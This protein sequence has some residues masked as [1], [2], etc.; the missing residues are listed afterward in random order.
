MS[1]PS[2]SGS[3][4]STASRS[5]S[6]ERAGAASPG[7]WSAE[8]RSTRSPR[9]APA[10][11]C[12][13]WRRP[14]T[15]PRPSVQAPQDHVAGIAEARPVAGRP[16]QLLVLE[17][18]KKRVPAVAAPLRLRPDAREGLRSQRV[19]ARDRDSRVVVE[20]AAHLHG[21]DDSPRPDLRCRPDARV[22]IDRLALPHPEQVEADDVANVHRDRGREGYGARDRRRLPSETVRQLRPDVARREKARQDD[23]WKGGQQEPD[24]P[25]VVE[26]LVE[27][28][29]AEKPREPREE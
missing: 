9:R 24:R 17:V 10:S 26:R 27:E 29:E 18:P 8:A 2:F 1:R 28:V 19:P 12:T 14:P 22:A 5:P 3:P 20:R 23:R 21:D 25:P 4:A 11:T 13:R 16:R 15:E 7:A 6:S